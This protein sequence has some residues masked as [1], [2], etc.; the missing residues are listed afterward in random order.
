MYTPCNQY[1]LHASVPVNPSVFL[2]VRVCEC[3]FSL[4][5]A[6]QVAL[7]LSAEV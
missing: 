1:V 2:F 5:A 7:K 6:I 4:S 3:D